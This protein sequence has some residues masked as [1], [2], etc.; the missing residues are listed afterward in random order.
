MSNNNNDQNNQDTVNVMG[1]DDIKKTPDDIRSTYPTPQEGKPKLSA[2]QM[3]GGPDDQGK[4]SGSTPAQGDDD[5][6]DDEVSDD[7]SIDL[8]PDVPEDYGV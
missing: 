4:R 6:N 8:K 7:G 3:A 5:L 2:H 1:P